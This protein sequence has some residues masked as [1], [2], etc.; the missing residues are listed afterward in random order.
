MHCTGR[1][2]RYHSQ[3]LLRPALPPLP[4]SAAPGDPDD[5]RK[6]EEFHS[7]IGQNRTQHESNAPRGSIVRRRV[8]REE[9]RSTSGGRS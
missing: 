7:V 4:A 1:N 2:L 8:A 9:T 3:R 6:S 5:Q